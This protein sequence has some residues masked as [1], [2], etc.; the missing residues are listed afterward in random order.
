MLAGGGEACTDIE[1]LR[2][3]SVLFGSV[4]LDDA[5]PCIPPARR[6]HPSGA[7]GGNGWCA[8]RGVVEELGH[9]WGGGVVPDID[10]SLHEIHSENKE[11]TAPHYKGG[12]GFHPIYCF[13]D[14]TGERVGVKLRP[15][16]AG[17][18]TIAD[19]VEVLDQAI[20]GLPAQVAAGHRP[21]DDPSLVERQLLLQE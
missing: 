6:R 10:S 1:Q 16:N 8:R 18:N 9:D 2:S 3:Q 4:P 21:G 17:A 14:G 7:V 12:F 19:Y 13:A 5:A 15:G 20:A 11:G